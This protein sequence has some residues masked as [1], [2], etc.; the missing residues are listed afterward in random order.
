MQ[1]YYSS[2]LWERVEDDDP[3]TVAIFLQFGARANDVRR[4]LP[5]SALGVAIT[6][7]NWT[8]I[9]ATKRRGDRTW[10][11]DSLHC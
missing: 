5:N 2:Q 11:C 1:D 6:Q 10:P 7:G 4:S 9:S 8:M 3:E